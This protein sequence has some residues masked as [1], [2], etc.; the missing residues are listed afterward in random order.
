[1]LKWVSLGILVRDVGANITEVQYRTST[2]VSEYFL[3]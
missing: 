1:M 2:W 3:S